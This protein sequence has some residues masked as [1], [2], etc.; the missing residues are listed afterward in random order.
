MSRKKKQNIKTHAHTYSQSSSLSFPDWVLKH[1][2]TRE[3][4]MVNMPITVAESGIAFHHLQ[5][6][7]EDIVGIF[8]LVKPF[9]RCHVH[10]HTG[11][12]VHG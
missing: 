11:D 3:T 10:R 4:E 8:D 12:F 1:R 6:R 7:E 5:L 2:L 9:N